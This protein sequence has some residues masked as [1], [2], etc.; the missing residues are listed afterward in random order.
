MASRIPA[1]VADAVLDGLEEGLDEIFPDPLARDY[2]EAYA[3]NPKA[4][5]QR[6]TE[7]SLALD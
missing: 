6:I 5:E 1:S 4:L 2:G 3:V 7:M